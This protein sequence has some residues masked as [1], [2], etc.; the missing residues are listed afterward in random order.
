[1]KYLFLIHSHTLLLTALGV[2]EKENIKD[3]DVYFIYYRN[4]STDLTIPYHTYDYSEEVENTYYIMFSWSR[5]NF[6]LNKKLRNKL[7]STFDLFVDN[8]IN[9]E[10]NLYCSSLD[11]P[12]NQ[13][14]ATNFK[15]KECFFI[16]EGGRCMRPEMSNQI[17]FVW[18]VYNRFIMKNERRLWKATNWFPNEKT[19]YNRPIT[20]YA[21]DKGYFC[22]SPTKL[23]MISWPK[24]DVNVHLNEHWPI[25]TLEGAVELGQ[26]SKN[27]YIKAVEKLIRKHSKDNNYIKF[28]PMQSE[29]MKIFY[30][31]LFKKYGKEVEI[32]PQNIPFELILTSHVGLTCIGFGTS[33]LFYAKALGHKVISEENELIKSSIR[34]RF[35]ARNLEKLEEIDV[36]I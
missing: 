10:Y 6:T 25:F 36:N 15:C 23:I 18:R 32:L 12:V 4:Y 31:N 35:Y 28:H 34:Y 21:F 33:L 22:N 26:I 16:Q 20:A 13:I 30:V 3:E 5:K 8:E 11:A 27:D 1:M 9:D 17:P 14:F 29:K 2:I 24:I 19:L 7:V